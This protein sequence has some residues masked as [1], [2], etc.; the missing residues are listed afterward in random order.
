M[1][2]PGAACFVGLFA[3]S[4][5]LSRLLGMVL[6]DLWGFPESLSAMKSAVEGMLVLGITTGSWCRGQSEMVFKDRRTFSPFAQ[7][8]MWKPLQK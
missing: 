4:I 8:R 3:V 6:A 2:I 7:L 5:A 1:D